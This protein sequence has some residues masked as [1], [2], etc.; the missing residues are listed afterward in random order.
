MCGE[1]ATIVTGVKSLTGSNGSA[2]YTLGLM[3]IAP[4]SARRNV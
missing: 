2:R 1:Y 4:M 3:A